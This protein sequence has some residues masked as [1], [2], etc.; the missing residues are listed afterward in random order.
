MRSSSSSTL[1]LSNG[2]INNPKAK[3]L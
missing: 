2:N 3:K 1:E